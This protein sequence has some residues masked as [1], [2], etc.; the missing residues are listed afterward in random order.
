MELKNG[1]NPIIDNL[2]FGQ[3]DYKD[4]PD[5]SDAFIESADKDGIPMTD[6][7]LDD[8]NEDGDFVHEKLMEYLY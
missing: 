5:F 7:E 1:G 2:S 8:L 3:I 6:E 4:A